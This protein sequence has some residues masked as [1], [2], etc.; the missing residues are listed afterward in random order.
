MKL[1][2]LSSVVAVLVV[3][4]VGCGKKSGDAAGT[5]TTTNAAAPAPGGGSCLLE[6]TGICYEYKDSALG[7]EE[8]ACKDM[9]KGKYAKAACPADNRIGSC[10]KD[11]DTTFYYVGSSR[12]PWVDDARDDCEKNPI[13]AGKFTAVAGADELAKKGALPAAD[14]IV[15]SCNDPSIGTCEDYAT[16]DVEI[17]KAGCDARKATFAR[18]ACPSEKLVASCVRRGETTRIYK[19]SALGTSAKDLEEQ[20]TKDPILPGHLY[21]AAGTALADNAKKGTAA[22]PAAAKAKSAKG[23]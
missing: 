9:L 12:T 23:K 20:C 8:A 7:L 1:G 14:R 3:A 10:V 17:E 6:K 13:K 16:E 5:T 15:A 11:D 18:S 19:G 4:T 2:T 22:P 21:L